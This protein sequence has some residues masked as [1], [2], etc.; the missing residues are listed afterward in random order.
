MGPPHLCEYTATHC[1][2]NNILLIK[3]F[4]TRNPWDRLVG[5]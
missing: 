1:L 5:L 3:I 2:Y 4:K